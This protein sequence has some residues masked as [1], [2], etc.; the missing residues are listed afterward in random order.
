MDIKKIYD[1]DDDAFNW[2]MTTSGR[3]WK[4]F[5][6][7]LKGRFFDESLTDDDLKKRNGDR[8]NDTDWDFLIKF[9]GILN[10]KLARQEQKQVVPSCSSLIHRAV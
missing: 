9:G 5:K 8:V 4:D 6:A 2:F 3:K 10:P 1:L 7:S